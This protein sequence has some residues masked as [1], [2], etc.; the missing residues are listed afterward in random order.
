MGDHVQQ[1]I[2]AIADHADQGVESGGKTDLQ[3]TFQ[4]IGELLAEDI[5]SIAGHI[6]GDIEVVGAHIQESIQVHHQITS[7]F[8]N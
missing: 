2:Q 6:Q 8:N 7:N 4:T 3:E 5:Q 1:D